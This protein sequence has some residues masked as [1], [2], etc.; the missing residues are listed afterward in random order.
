M[1]KIFVL[2]VLFGFQIGHSQKLTKKDFL[3]IEKNIYK[4]ALHNFDLDAAKNAIYQIIGVEGEQSKYIDSLAY[5]YFNQQKYLSCVSVA[6]KI[7]Q[8]EKKLPILELKAVSLENLN[9]I[10]EAI[11]AYEQVFAQKKEPFVAYKLANLQH[12]LK[13]SAEAYTTLKSTENGNF[14]P[15]ASVSFPTAKKGVTQQV[16]LKAAYYNLL[17]MT[18]YDLHNYDLA[19]GY[20]EKALQVYPEFFVAKQNKQAIELMQKKLQSKPQE[21]NKTNK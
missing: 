10:K 14:P 4:E 1:K 21:S 13:R 11:A 20:F 8:K 2:L 16:P 5:L 19:T 6:D 7:L 18:S 15:K 12:K 3:T 9:A 17:A